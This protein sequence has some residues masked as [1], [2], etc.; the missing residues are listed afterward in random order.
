[1]HQVGT[2]QHQ[3]GT[4]QLE[5]I[6]L[7]R[8]K[9]QEKAASPTFWSLKKQPFSVSLHLETSKVEKYRGREQG[10]RTV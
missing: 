3:E 6:P 5:R 1:M 9:T 10:R 4:G 7:D 8:K 2:A